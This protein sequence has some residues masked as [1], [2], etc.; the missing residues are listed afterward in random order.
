MCISI[1]IYICIY[2]LAGACQTA[3]P[4]ESPRQSGVTSQNSGGPRH[5]SREALED[6]CWACGRPSGLFVDFRVLTESHG[7]VE[8]TARE[9]WGG[10]KAG[11]DRGAVHIVQVD[12]DLLQGPLAS[13]SADALPESTIHEPGAGRAIDSCTGAT[14]V[15][16]RIRL[17]RQGA[18]CLSGACCGPER[19]REVSGERRLDLQERE[20]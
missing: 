9:A 20:L 2:T 17:A 4:S 13:I 14:K 10:G 1:Y 18:P 16:L 3:L 11:P 12:L 7:R 19:L 8:K 6:A 5:W 15:V